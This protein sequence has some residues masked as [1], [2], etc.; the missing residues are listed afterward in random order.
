MLRITAVSA[1]AV[2]YL[3][4]GSGCCAKDPAHDHEH[5]MTPEQAREHEQARLR[6]TGPARGAARYFGSAVEHGE[7][8]GR[9]GGQGL[10]MFGVRPGEE[11]SEAMVRAIFGN[12]EDP[13]T[14]DP[15]GRA[16]RKF[17]TTA[18]RQKAAV[19]AAGPD[20][21]PEQQRQIEVTAA[22]D[23]R[24]A[25]AY[26]DF[27]FSPPKSVSVYYAALMAAGDFAGA[28]QVA[29]AHD[30]AV[31]VAM[32]YAE[33]H[34]GYTRTGY[35][36]R[37]QDGRSVGRYEAGAGLIW[38][39]WKH[40]TNRES[41]PQLHTHVAVLNRLKT[42]SDGLI[43]ALDGRGIR[44][45][46]E[47][48][49]TA[50][51]RALEEGIVAVRGVVFADRA[52]GKAREIVGVD[53]QMCAEASTRRAQ[54]LA[55]AEELTALFIAR[56]GY[57]PD[58]AA[59]K[60]ILD[61]AAMSTRKAKEGVAGPAAV[62]AWAQ[63]RAAQLVAT[64]EAV[65]DA[66]EAAVV[67]GHPDVVAGLR[68]DPT[69]PEQRAA[70]LAAA[71][72]DVQHEYATWTVGNL[73][74]AIDKRI[75][76]LPAEMSG[77]ARPAYMEALAREAVEPGNGHGVALLTA[78]DPVTV[79][80]Q[81]R[82]SEDGRSIF[83]PHIDERY[84]TLA[85]LATEERV[86]TGARQL[87]AP[88]IRGPELEMLR[89]ELAAAG[90]GPDQVAAVVGIVSSGRAGDVLIGPAGTG[91]S[92]TV[93]ALAGVWGERVGGRVLGL[94][95]TEIATQNLAA[96]GVPAMNTARFL[97]AF[98]P[99]P[100]GQEPRAR[101]GRGDLFVIDEAGMSGTPELARIHDI[102]AAGGG[103]LVY[104][105]DHGQLTSV[106]AGGMLALL[107]ADNGAYEL[108]Q[109]HRFGNAWERE[110][111]L[112]LRGGD[113]SVIPEY[114]DRGRLQGGT[115]EEMQA[116]AMRAYLADTLT[117]KES[118]L[119]VGSNADAATLSADIRDQLIR[120]GK[121]ER[122]SVSELGS[123]T[124]HVRVSVG[125]RV[126]ARMVDRTI[127]VDGGGIVANRAVYT[128]LGVDEDGALRVRGARG[129]VAH[130]PRSY[131]DE[132][133]TLAYASTVHAAQGRTVDTSHAL[134]DEAAAREA[135][136]VALSRGREANYAYLVAQ[137]APDAH[138][139]ERLDD[140]AAGRLAGVLGNVEARNAAEV[141]RRIGERDGASLAWIGTQWD[142]V[143]RE[144]AQARYTGQLEQV[145]PAEAVEAL[146]AEPGWARLVRAVREAELAGHNS[147]ALLTGA[148]EGRPLADAEQVSDVLR[149][150]VRILAADRTPEQQVG[151]GD[152]TAL[153]PPTDGPV[154]QFSH[155]LAVLA[156][157]RQYELGQAALA[158]PPA[159][160]VEQLG[161]VPN[162]DELTRSVENGVPVPVGAVDQ[163]AEA[164][165]EWARGAGAVAAYRELRGIDPDTTSIGAAPSREEEFHRQMWTQAAAALGQNTDP[166]AVDYRTLPDLDLYAAREQWTREQAWA[167]EYVAGE[168][169]TAYELARQYGEDAALAGAKLATL[170][171]DDAEWEPNAQQLER[172]DRLAELNEERARQLE[173]IH[174]ARGGW[175]GAT[176]D[177]R[178]ADE[179]ARDELARRGLPPQRELVP[180]EQLEL[181][182]AEHVDVGRDIGVDPAAEV[183]TEQTIA[184]SAE[185][186]IV[187]EPA[188][189]TDVDAAL[190]LVAD[191]EVELDD[192]ELEEQAHTAAPTEPVR[193]RI[194]EPEPAVAVAREPVIEPVAE[195]VEQLTLLDVEPTV[196]VQ[197]SAEPLRP[198]ETAAAAEPAADAAEERARLTLAEARAQAEAAEQMRTAREAVEA[199]RSAA[200]AERTASPAA[201]PV[202]HQEDVE[203][204]AQLVRSTEHDR[205]VDPARTVPERDLGEGADDKLA[206]DY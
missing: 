195:K 121:V 41:E 12:L 111:S 140:S 109:V 74:A 106:G 86:V 85:Q 84:A 58:A 46:K 73:V 162:Y 157:D 99:G 75:G 27:T 139:A 11:A 49:A 129:E 48:I 24:K 81:L 38:T 141:E 92:Y 118:L 79:P 78:A 72:A 54:T 132:H 184:T 156:Q 167:P 153:A 65:A 131:V 44:P 13:E 31:E 169:R 145:L 116:A 36:G 125:D 122:E 202:Q 119:I 199:A 60:A 191:V 168:M 30:R 177:A 112:R 88:V 185:G 152:W 180:A 124:G 148:I 108:E 15:L 113:R 192:V 151:A 7:P 171:P 17:K 176:E 204:Q 103:K 71:I 66:A 173:E 34:V 187:D 160:A 183:A 51:E 94:A 134:L 100:D 21:T 82:R 149:Y 19:A 101:V 67:A 68:L 28:E 159:W 56:N 114:E 182:P 16:P 117:G 128:V 52:D 26:Y 181:F 57:E 142:E 89:V 150:R 170:E 4:R 20:I 115:R 154:G 110:A 10:A 59:R 206:I 143:S 53:P 55:K 22:A 196:T 189:T 37:T 179:L 97:A 96:D 194:D 29:R 107:V 70:L 190:E 137:R 35:H 203:R 77:D 175:Y 105:G 40:S 127:R 18:E 178:T 14:G 136:Y 87:T 163:I 9:W 50:Y 172:S 62:A 93:T 3:I 120:L 83:R 144:S 186:G 1:G 76:A 123:R 23:G 91:K 45:V 126:Q 188:V 205:A 200:A 104:T 69:V 164:R 197:V 166:R 193:E 39:G 158:D 32:A 98:T 47:A 165:M 147:A 80:A 61:D 155:E 2:D 198:T 42:L 161:P 95:T 6:T 63:P 8:A 90:L 146:T 174:H 138:D 102:V 64:V 135:A 25:V 133:L 33:A 130:L 5:A 43:R 201:E